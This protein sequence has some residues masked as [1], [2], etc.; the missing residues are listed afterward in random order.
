MVSIKII[1]CAAKIQYILQIC[2]KI[3]ENVQ[4]LLL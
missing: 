3:E 1:I 2:K 4:I